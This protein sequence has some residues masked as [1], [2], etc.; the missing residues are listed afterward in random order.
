MDNKAEIVMVP[1]KKLKPHPKNAKLHPE[2]QIKKIAASIHDYGFNNPIIIDSSFTII[3]G[4]GRSQAAKFLKMKSIPSIMVDHMSENE[5]RAY[6]IAD[7]KVAESGYDMEILTDEL[8]ELSLKG[9]DPVTLGFD[10]KEMENIAK[11]AAES[12]EIIEITEACE[13]AEGDTWSCGR[14]TIVIGKKH[15]RTKDIADKMINSEPM[16]IFLSEKHAGPLLSHFQNDG[17][18]IKKEESL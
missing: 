1:I 13:A 9:L 6:L 7:N 11:A 17:W 12:D 4:H 8:F 5:K 10:D 3:A 18:E 16:T 14:H 15:L 2:K